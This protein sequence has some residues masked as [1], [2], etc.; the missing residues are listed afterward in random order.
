MMQAPWSR[1]AK[2]E[3]CVVSLPMKTTGQ[4]TVPRVLPLHAAGSA[5]SGCITGSII[6]PL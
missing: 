3:N 2:R 4:L 6:R 1:P 5:R